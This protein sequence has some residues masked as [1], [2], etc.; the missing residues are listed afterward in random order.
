MPPTTPQARSKVLVIGGGPA[1]AMAASLLGREGIETTVLEREKFPRYHIGESLLTAI[2]PILDLAGV[3]DK[4]DQFG[5]VK[6]YS[7]FF[8]VKQG[9]P[10]GHVD[11][12]R[13]RIYKY[14]YQV[15]RSEFDKLMLDH[16]RESG[17]QVFEETRVF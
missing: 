5:F 17:A 2:H 6:K 13:N 12:R 7:G 1:G 15:R 11:F 3:R 10:A 4:I 16:A 8:R 14:S 9:I